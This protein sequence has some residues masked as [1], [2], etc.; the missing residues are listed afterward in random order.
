MTEPRS[1][2]RYL[3]PWLIARVSR[4]A[5][6]S[7]QLADFRDWVLT[8][9]DA[10]ANYTDRYAPPALETYD[11]NGEVVNRIVANP[12]YDGQH[13]ELY[14]RGIIGLPYS[15]QAPMYSRSPWATCWHRLTSAC[16]AR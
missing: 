8:E 15:E 11:R 10:Q 3:E 9:V 13:Q 5:D 4:M 6:Y 2:D 1:F 12:W 7:T 16:T 14:R